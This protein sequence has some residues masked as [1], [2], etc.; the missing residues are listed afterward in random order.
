MQALAMVW[1]QAWS[2]KVDKRV[3]LIVGK[4]LE[5]RIQTKSMDIAIPL[6]KM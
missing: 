3:A 6:G 2:T 4:V 5:E 1:E